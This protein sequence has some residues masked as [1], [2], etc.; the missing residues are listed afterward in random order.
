MRLWHVPSFTS[1]Q[2]LL[3]STSPTLHPAFGKRPKFRADCKRG[4]LELGI[5]WGVCGLIRPPKW[6]SARRSFTYR[7][8]KAARSIGCS[9]QASETRGFRLPIGDRKLRILTAATWGRS[10]QAVHARGE[11][12]AG[13]MDRAVHPIYFRG[14]LGGDLKNRTTGKSENKRED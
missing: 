5:P 3:L 8:R 1:G 2:H 14:W 13:D 9:K 4:F 7:R 11:S 10:M 6:W 12:S